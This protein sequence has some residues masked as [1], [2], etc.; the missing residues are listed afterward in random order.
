LLSQSTDEHSSS[1]QDGVNTAN[2]PARAFPAPTATQLDADNAH[3]LADA[4]NQEGK[5]GAAATVVALVTANALT[6]TTSPTV[7][8]LDPRVSPREAWKDG[9]AWKNSEVWSAW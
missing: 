1:D 7:L 4:P 3:V 2:G 6:A 8:R 9:K 5:Y